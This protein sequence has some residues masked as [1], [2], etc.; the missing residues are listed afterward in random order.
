MYGTAHSAILYFHLQQLHDQPER[1]S[2]PSRQSI[3]HSI[4]EIERSGEGELLEL[5]PTIPS[6]H[7][8]KA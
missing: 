6:M 7:M 3:S 1:E 2:V 8:A 5:I 4:T